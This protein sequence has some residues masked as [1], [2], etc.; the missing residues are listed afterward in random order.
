[1]TPLTPLRG[2]VRDGTRST[3]RLMRSSTRAALVA[4]TVAGGIA[5]A[6]PVAGFAARPAPTYVLRGVVVQY[7]PP[8]GSTVGSLSVRVTR[9]RGAGR[10]LAGELV[11]VA[12]VSGGNLQSKRQTLPAGSVCTLVLS[13]PSP[14]SILKGAGA[15]RNIVIAGPAALPPTPPPSTGD[16]IP[17]QAN[18]PGADGG[19]SAGDGANKAGNETGPAKGG[20]DAGKGDDG[21]GDSGKSDSGKSDSGKTDSGKTDSGGGSSSGSADKGSGRH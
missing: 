17:G 14:A 4:C 8:A 15:L 10:R 5:A 7:I 12:I 18:D 9:V 1:M 16:G 21:K 3:I 6:G 20:G 19:S 2:I 13:A 11:T